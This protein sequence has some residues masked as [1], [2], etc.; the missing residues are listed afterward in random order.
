MLWC[1]LNASL[2]HHIAKCAGTARDRIVA[3]VQVWSGVEPTKKDGLC[4]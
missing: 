3:V 1:R 2:T 4:R